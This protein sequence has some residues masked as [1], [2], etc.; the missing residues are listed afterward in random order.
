MA[1]KRYKLTLMG[2]RGDAQPAK[3]VAQRGGGQH[4]PG[5]LALALALALFTFY[6]PAAAAVFGGNGTPLV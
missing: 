2:A 1:L 4:G 3:I 6:F 5:L